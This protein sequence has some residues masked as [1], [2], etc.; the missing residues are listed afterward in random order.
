MALNIDQQIIELIQKSK[1]I[2]IVVPPNDEGD[3]LASALAL[4]N[5]I[6]KDNRPVDLFADQQLKERFSFLPHA[7]KIKTELTALKKL[8]ISLNL[9]HNKVHEFYYDVNHNHLNIYIAP[10]HEPLNPQDVKISNSDFKYDLIITLGAQDLESLGNIYQQQPDFFYQTPIINIDNDAANEHYG[11][12]NLVKLNITSLAEIIF[13]LIQNI[14]PTALTEETATQL[15]TGVIISTQSF[16]LPGLNPQTLMTASQLIKAGADRQFII[17]QLNKN[18]KI[19][20]LNLWGRALARLKQD[21]HY[22]LAW[23]LLNQNDFKKSGAKPEDLNGVVNELIS[24]SPKI[25]VTLILFED[26]DGYIAGL[27]FASPNFNALELSRPFGGQ[28]TAKRASFKTEYRQLNI[29]ETEILEQIRQR[30]NY[31]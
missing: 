2:L 18:K 28:G 17:N 30:L 15:L 9:N 4:K 14:K 7:E 20:S 31:L 6:E 22:K 13:Q 11:Q 29:A 21:T 23:T 10:Q 8:V 24:G 5:F 27:I 12:I 16:R 19:S 1:H 25:E 26:N 3:A